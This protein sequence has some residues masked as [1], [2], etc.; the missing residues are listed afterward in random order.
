MAGSL[1]IEAVRPD[2]PGTPG[3]SPDTSDDALETNG[4]ESTGN[5]SQVVAALIGSR[6]RLLD[7]TST[8]SVE[9]A[10]RR[11]LEQAVEDDRETLRAVAYRLHEAGVGR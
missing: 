9:E 4:A 11:A 7:V 10:G 5:L 1:R 2:V 6:R 3:G 8:A